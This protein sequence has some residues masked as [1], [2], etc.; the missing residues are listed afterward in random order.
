MDAECRL[1]HGLNISCLEKIFLFLPSEDLITLGE[2]NGFYKQ[3]IH[4]CVIKKCLIHL[5]PK[6]IS[7][8]EFFESYGHRLE[9]F[10]FAGRVPQFEKFNRLISAGCS[11]DQ[12]KNVQLKV[13][14]V[15]NTI[16][17]Q[18]PTHFRR[19]EKFKFSTILKNIRL[20]LSF[21][22]SLRFLHLEAVILASSFN[23]NE[24]KNLMELHLI[25]VK[26]VNVHNF[27]DYIRQQPK[28]EHFYQFESFEM[29][30]M[31]DI[32]SL[33]AEQMGHQI[34]I[35]HDRLISRSISSNHYE[36]LS[37]F[38]NVKEVLLTTNVM[39][40]G[41]LLAPITKLAEINTIEKL[42]IHFNGAYA[43]C[44]F[45]TSSKNI[46][47]K[48]FSHLKS[49]HIEGYHG[50]I[51]QLQNCEPMKLFTTYS[52][53]IL[54]N[55]E[56]LSISDCSHKEILNMKYLKNFPKLRRFAINKCNLNGL[57]SGQAAKIFSCIQN[58][59]QQR[60]H[61][62][63]EN[64]SHDIIYMTVHSEQLEKFREINN[65]EKFIKFTVCDDHGK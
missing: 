47:M 5:P 39:C 40:A 53:E 27:M 28:I 50:Q 6:R 57:E 58:I 43:P 46:N 23:W 31:Q 65:V 33:I 36:Y 54:S 20:H 4:D 19:V 55:V 15:A 59:L 52:S 16:D 9:N 26:N 12:L 37:G 8:E 61:E 2:M 32:G 60:T 1:R 45:H 21:S 51:D 49:I 56:H 44:I 22:E 62:R 10:I 38:K 7:I 24:L 30:S 18:S 35:I 13:A 63:N 11:V 34:R 48:T 17:I 64:Y 29:K 25:G 14:N 42:I 41:D 3:I